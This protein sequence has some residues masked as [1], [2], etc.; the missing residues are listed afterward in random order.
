[1]EPMKLLTQGS[2]TLTA[3]SLIAALALSLAAS[4]QAADQK[5][6]VQGSFHSAKDP[7]L[8]PLPFNPHPELSAVEVEKGVYVVDDTAI[9]DTAAQAA[10]RNAR[11][12]AREEAKAIASNP[13]AAQAA[14]AASAAAQEAS[15]ATIIEEVSPWLHAPIQMPDG[16]P[17][18]SLQDLTDAQAM[19]TSSNADAIIAEQQAALDDAIAWGATNGWPAVI[20]TDDS[21]RGY[22]VS[23]DEN[24]PQYLMPF[25]LA[26]AVTVST[27]NVWPGGPTG[28]NLT[29]TNVTISMW[30]EASPRLTHIELSPRVTELDGNTTN[31]DH[32]TAVAGILVGVGVNL[33]S[34]TN[35]LGPLA[36]GMAYAA[37]VQA[38]DFTIDLGEMTGAVGTNH[39]RLSNQSYG[40][41]A[42]WYYAG[43]GVWE[44]FGYASV[45]AT[46]D[47]AFGNYTTNASN[48]D[49]LI[50]GA[51]TYLQV[52]SAGNDQG[53]APPVQ[54]TNHLE[55]TGY[56]TTYRPPDGDEGGY[57]TM[58]QQGCAKNV[59]TVGAI[60]PLTNGYSG[61]TNV[62]L[63]PFSSCGPTDDGRIK[64]DL[65]ADG[66]NDITPGAASDT[67]Y[68]NGLCR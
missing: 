33:Y 62:V 49:N 32:S 10:A 59:L 46:Q 47:P 56:T 29:G 22:L 31:S 26:E 36:K 58:S 65:V 14:Q 25:G 2:T 37:N 30:D 57:D 44:W 60:Y 54:P 51:P 7:D 12:A 61:P 55:R 6:Q 52:W 4:I 38:R 21:P 5:A 23:R 35:L 67:N 3:L 8:P 50:Q 27:T 64:P 41:I 13:L 48:Y 19:I 39:M 28:F 45:S 34:G 20:G 66:I 68:V 24:G 17:A 63:A 1:M 15:F 16:A 18:P 40:W 43:G 42:G 9:P 53:E 11:Q